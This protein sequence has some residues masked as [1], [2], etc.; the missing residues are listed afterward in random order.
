MNPHLY[1]PLIYNKDVRL[2]N[3]EKTAFSINGVGKT[4]QLPVKESNWTTFSH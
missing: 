4:G 2:Y 3:K 1:V